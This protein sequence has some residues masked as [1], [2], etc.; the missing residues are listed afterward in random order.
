MR[1]QQPQRA[2]PL[3]PGG[4]CYHL[5]MSH[6]GMGAV[7]QVGVDMSRFRAFPYRGSLLRKIDGHVQEVFH[8]PISA[9]VLVER[10]EL[11]RHI[12]DEAQRLVPERITFHWQLA[13]KEVDL[14][15]QTATF[16]GPDGA[17]HELRYDL[18]VGA[19]GVNSRVRD[20]MAQ[21]VPG[22]R[23]R[24][25]GRMHRIDKF[26]HHVQPPPGSALQTPSSELDASAT[27]LRFYYVDSPPP[28]TVGLF[29]IHNHADGTYSG[30]VSFTRADESEV[31]V[32]V[33]S[34]GSLRTA[35]DF[36]AALGGLTMYPQEMRAAIAEQLAARP[37]YTS[38]STLQVSRL[39]GPRVV[40]IGDAAHAVSAAFG[41]G[42]NSA[43]EDCT[44]LAE[45]LAGAA[46][47]VDAALRHYERRRRPDAH[48]LGTMD[49]Q[50]EAFAGFRGK[51]NLSYWVF[52]THM[53]VNG[54]LHRLLPGRF[55]DPGLGPL[56]VASYGCD[57]R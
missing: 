24:W 33:G 45:A 53:L 22:F 37:W 32:G 7:E 34:G 44:V 9:K 51:W 6:R 26:F 3:P 15:R 29:F 55:G 17:L 48:A 46:G 16:S 10:M 13:C 1:Q 11:V 21:Q 28:L 52:Q 30:G 23:Q 8:E 18:L 20:A 25:S 57:E 40:L 35:A 43:L 12:V 38:G 27:V 2:R 54:W 49:H 14:A 4:Q 56:Y 47:D 5:A 39:T 50:A 36:E 31:G 19:D 42:V 41:Q